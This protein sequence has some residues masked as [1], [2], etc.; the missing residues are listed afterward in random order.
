MKTTFKNFPQASGIT[1]ASKRAVSKTNPTVGDEF[2]ENHGK[3]CRW[4]GGGALL[5]ALAGSLAPTPA[6]AAVCTDCY[7]E[8]TIQVQGKAPWNPDGYDGSGSG[9]GRSGSP[10]MRPR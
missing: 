4:I 9:V 6:S 8:E 5:L 3:W 7:G 10:S 2:P 1:N